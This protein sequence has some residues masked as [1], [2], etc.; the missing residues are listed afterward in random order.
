MIDWLIV[1]IVSAFIVGG[2]VIGVIEYTDSWW[3]ID[4]WR[5]KRIPP[6]EEKAQVLTPKDYTIKIIHPELGMIIPRGI[7]KKPDGK[8]DLLDKNSLPIAELNWKQLRLKN[9]R[10]IFDGITTEFVFEITDDL[11]LD[12]LSARYEALWLN[13]QNTL[14]EMKAQSKM[15]DQVRL[16]RKKGERALWDAEYKGRSKFHPYSKGKSR[17]EPQMSDEGM[18]E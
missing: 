3:L 14:A 18:E 15:Q 7:T 2:A 9:A 17:L 4:E 6:K 1:L 12:A 16:D 8:F 13:Y 5:G 11:A 10:S